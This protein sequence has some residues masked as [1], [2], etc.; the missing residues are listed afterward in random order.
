MQLR[1]FSSPDQSYRVG[2]LLWN[3]CSH[4][5]LR[6]PAL[7]EKKSFFRIKA[8]KVTW[9][10]LSV[11]LWGSVDILLLTFTLYIISY[12]VL[13]ELVPPPKFLSVEDGK[14]PTKKWKSE[15]KLHIFMLDRFTFTFLVGILPS[16]TQRTFGGG[17]RKKFDWAGWLIKKTGK[18]W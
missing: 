16:S 4:L 18:N 2:S 14:I 13:F 3:R 10:S 1:T 11:G 5:D 9:T 17:T 15:L 8:I 6:P 7:V 12:R